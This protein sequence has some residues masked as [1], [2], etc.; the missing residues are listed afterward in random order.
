MAELR[1]LVS[2]PHGEEPEHGQEGSGDS[3]D[4][5]GEENREHVT[6]GPLWGG[7]G[8]PHVGEPEGCQEEPTIHDRTNFVSSEL[9]RGDDR[10]GGKP[11]DA[12]VLEVEQQTQDIDRDPAEDS[13]PHEFDGGEHGVGED[14]A[15]GG[16]EGGGTRE[17]KVS[18]ASEHGCARDEQVDHG[19]KSER[20]RPKKGEKG[21]LEWVPNDSAQFG[22]EITAAAGVGIP[23]GNDA[24]S[25]G[26]G[27]EETWWGV[28]G[29]KVAVA[30]KFAGEDA[31]ERDEE[32]QE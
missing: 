26:F 13:I 7:E 5:Q 1:E 3:G 31:A 21:Q 25:Q 2:S 18:S 23:E 24:M 4:R 8:R 11:K 30:E 22:E 32:E 29:I 19:K 15:R 20:A 12:A 10:D 6:R 16:D 9:H 17:M 14:S 28:D 27:E